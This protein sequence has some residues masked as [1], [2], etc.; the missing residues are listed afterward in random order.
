MSESSDFDLY[1]EALVALSGA[2]SRQREALR[3]AV[4]SS[5]T[6]KA[7]AK[8]QMADQARM[9][10][11]AGQEA[12][13]AERSLAEIRR[14]LGQ[15]A[16]SSTSSPAAA[17]EVAQLVQIRARIRG[18]QSWADESIP[19]IESLMRTRARL[20]QNSNV[21]ETDQKESEPKAVG[22]AR[23]VLVA[24]FVVAALAALVI[25]LIAT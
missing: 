14:M 6:S 18:V 9:F 3:K 16:T 11:R 23:T 5:S 4:E 19:V 12:L 15:P 22:K 8:A 25:A 20:A 2:A 13:E 21:V 1:A 24:L 7:T 10:D 17:G